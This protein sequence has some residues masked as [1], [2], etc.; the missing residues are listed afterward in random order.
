MTQR[1]RSRSI[2]QTLVNITMLTSTIALVIATTIFIV[3]DLFSTR[4]SL[5]EGL[6]T[7]A[8]ITGINC[9]AALTFNDSK[10]AEENLQTFTA[11]PKI[12]QA[13]VL[14]AESKI[15]ARYPANKRDKDPDRDQFLSQL[16]QPIPDSATTIQILQGNHRF[17]GRHLHLVEPIIFEGEY[18]GWIYLLGDMADFYQRLKWDALICFFILIFCSSVAFLLSKKLQHRI[19]API[20]NLA[21]AM[22]Q[23]SRDKNYKLRVKSSR[24]DEIGTLIKGFNEMLTQIQK[25]DRAL[26]LTQYSIDHMA[27]AAFWTQKPG[28]IIY[29][30]TAACQKWGYIDEELTRMTLSDIDVENTAA[31]MEQIWDNLNPNESLSF[32]TIHQNKMGHLFP[33]E[34][35]ISRVDFEGQAYHCCFARDISDRKEMMRQLQQAQKMEA[36]GTLAAGVAHDLNNVL[37]G[38][39]SYPELLLLEIP[40]ENH[41]YDIVQTIQKSGQKAAD[42]VQDLLT[43][44]RRGVATSTTA[45]TNLNAIVS[46]YMN[47]PEYTKLCSYH[48]N[49]KVVTEL[50]QNLFN[51]TGSQ[52]HIAKT[53]MNMVSNAAEAM[54]TGG[55]LT[56]KTENRS[57][58]QPVNGYEKIEAGDYAVLIVSDTGIGISS[59][60]LKKIFEPFFTKKVMG[61]S[62]TGLGMSVVWATVKDHHG[63][64]NVYSNEG[65]GTSF[66]LFFPITFHNL[67][68]PINRFSIDNYLGNESILVV[69]DIV[70]QRE[71]ASRI[72][73]KL[74]YHV[75]TVESGEKAIAYLSKRRIDLVVLDMIMEPGINGL[76]T[77]RRILEIH[78]NQ[79][80]VIA[81]GFS[82][83]EDVQEVQRLGAGLYVK[84]PYTLEKIGYAVRKVLSPD[85]DR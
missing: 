29:A 64:V 14:T 41:M 43:L 81:S 30:N 40:K 59:E 13:L 74:G 62:G 19:S 73:S 9:A 68:P 31:Q 72:L 54:P 33:V 17:H 85:F 80:A 11:V 27:D 7:V 71:I 10:A 15:F 6:F 61:R 34:I 47:S 52:V 32:E 48:S 75:T 58:D 2:T 22:D 4:K 82:E 50:S 77:Y 23:I 24:K 70:E 18:L 78:P 53:V 37:G 1:F 16:H 69:D 49:V 25:Q 8:R 42:I 67:A 21:S 26:R 66:E 51:I 36:I 20:L 84:K 44:A 83:S 63:F 38:L 56:I 79:K 55:K 46:D 12:K 76:E 39:V 57:I 28:K 45:T 3:N 65:D 5:K 35:T 60:D